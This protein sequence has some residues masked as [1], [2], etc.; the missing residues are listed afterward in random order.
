MASHQITR[1]RNVANLNIESLAEVTVMPTPIWK[2]K[3]NIFYPFST[4]QDENGKRSVLELNMKGTV[5]KSFLRAGA[6][7]HTIVIE[8]S[9]KNIEE[10]KSLIKTVPVPEF[11][12]QHY[13]W[14]WEG[15]KVRFTSKRDLNSEF[16]FI[17]N[18]AEVNWSKVEER[19]KAAMDEVKEGATVVIEYTP[20]SYL[21]RIE[22]DGVAGFESGCSLQ[23]LSIGVLSEGDFKEFDFDSPKKRKRMAD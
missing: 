2:K 12:E 9:G 15:S 6:L 22:T 16:K 21:G 4:T 18:G 17:W 3:G 10:L 13:R 20:L 19:K 8:S 5:V 14:P 1:K 23:L 7:S 11:S